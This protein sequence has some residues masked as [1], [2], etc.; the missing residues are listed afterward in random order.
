MSPVPSRTF[1]RDWKDQIL[2]F[3]QTSMTLFST[4]PTGGIVRG[5]VYVSFG[6]VEWELV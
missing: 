6:L 4:E 3:F 5:I 1:P 2:C